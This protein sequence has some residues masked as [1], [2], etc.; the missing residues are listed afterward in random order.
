MRR[1]GL[2]VNAKKTFFA[3]SELECLG[4][5][6]TRKGIQSMPKK[7]DGM[8]QLQEPK[9]RE[10]LHGFVGVIDCC[11]NMLWK[12]RPHMLAP[13]ASLTSANIPWKWGQ[14]QS[15]AFLEANKILNEEAPLA[16]PVFDK[17]FIIQADASHQQ[18]G[19]VVS[20]DM[21]MG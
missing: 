18:L 5:W 6:V 4:H 11:R 12:Q 7:V 9:T 17:P 19:A 15:E 3:K 2:K 8:M 20:Q 21:E 1:A 14:E 13:L 16:C 10:R